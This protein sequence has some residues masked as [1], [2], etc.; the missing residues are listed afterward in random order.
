MIKAFRFKYSSGSDYLLKSSC[1]FFFVPYV[2]RKNLGF[3][4]SL[5]KF[6]N[7][8]ALL[9]NYLLRN[10]LSLNDSFLISPRGYEIVDSVEGSLTFEVYW[11]LR[12]EEVLEGLGIDVD[13]REILV[14]V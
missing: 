2:G 1:V 5:L 10:H 8:K 14:S 3:P 6:I 7:N 12:N 13:K 4:L 11:Q 9:D